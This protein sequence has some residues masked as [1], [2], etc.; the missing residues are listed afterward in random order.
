[1]NKLRFCRSG[2]I[3]YCSA[4]DANADARRYLRFSYF[5]A[6]LCPDCGFWHLTHRT[7]MNLHRRR[8]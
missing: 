4:D 6:Y 2:K 3:A 5:R 7:F 1:M 8:P